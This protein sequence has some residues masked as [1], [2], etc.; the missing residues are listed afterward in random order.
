MRNYRTE[1]FIIAA[2]LLLM[3]FFVGGGIKDLAKPERTVFVRGLAEMEVKANHVT[4]PILYKEAGNDLLALC[5][6]VNKS[7]DVIVEFLKNEGVGEEEISINP[8][9]VYDTNTDRYS[10]QNTEFRYNVTSV[11]TV[12]TTKVDLVRR[13]INRQGELLGKGI[14]IVDGDYRYRVDY[15]YTDL[16]TVKPKMIE[17][18]TKNARAAAQKFAIDSDSELGKIKQASQGQFEISDRDQN[19][20]Y[21]KNVRVVTSLTYYLED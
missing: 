2:G 15:E 20:P 12:S 1:A 16:N 5:N 14:V 19:T 17:E 21:I 18:A 11:I 3:G 7:N 4:W 6:K 8:L 13:L 10:N 9:E